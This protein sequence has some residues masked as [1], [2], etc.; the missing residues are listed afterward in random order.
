MDKAIEIMQALLYKVDALQVEIYEG[1]KDKRPQ[2]R[3]RMRAE[4]QVGI[5]Y[6]VKRWIKEKMKESEE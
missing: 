2:S 5:L 3:D 1:V 4:A 6:V